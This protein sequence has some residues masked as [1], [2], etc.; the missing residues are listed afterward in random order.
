MTC[1]NLRNISERNEILPRNID[2]LKILLI[3]NPKTTNVQDNEG[4]TALHNVVISYIASNS[5]G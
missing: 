5:K 2:V 4:F 1:W 3:A